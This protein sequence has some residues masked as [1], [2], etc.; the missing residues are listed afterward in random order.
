MLVERP[1]SGAPT[2]KVSCAKKS[3]KEYKA[4]SNGVGTNLKNDA[5]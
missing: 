4:K 5:A 2:A 1:I 3:A